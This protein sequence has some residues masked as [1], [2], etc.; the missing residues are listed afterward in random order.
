M[1]SLSKSRREAEAFRYQAP[2]L[3]KAPQATARGAAIKTGLNTFL[4]CRAHSQGRSRFLCMWVLCT[5]R[6]H[7]RFC[8]VCICMSRKHILSSFIFSRRC[9]SGRPQRYR[10]GPRPQQ[11]F[12]HSR[13]ASPHQ[14]CSA[15]CGNG[16]LR[17][18]HRLPA[19]HGVPPV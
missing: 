7:C 2:L 19:A 8:L 9:M 18:A 4:F 6:F 16:A 14:M 5:L 1:V 3:W 10:H 15:V 12:V 17:L 11:V 13:V